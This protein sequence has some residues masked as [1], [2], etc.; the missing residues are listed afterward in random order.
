MPQKYLDDTPY[1]EQLF[2]GKLITGREGFLVGKD[3]FTLLQNMRYGP[4]GVGLESRLGMRRF[5]NTAVGSGADIDK[6]WQHLYTF[7]Q[8]RQEDVYCVTDE[9]KLY[10]ADSVPEA[11]AG[12]G[13][14]GTSLYDFTTSAGVPSFCAIDNHA[15]CSSKKDLIGYSGATPYAASVLYGTDIGTADTAAD[16][17]D[18]TF[19]I[20]TDEVTNSDT[21]RYITIT[22]DTQ[23]NNEC[24]YVGFWQPVDGIT[25]TLGTNLNA[26][27][28][29][30][31]TVE[32]WNG[33]AW[34]ALTISD[35]TEQ[36]ADTPFSQ[37]GTISWTYIAVGT[38][39]P[40]RINGLTLFWYRIQT[41]TTLDNFDLTKVTVTKDWRDIEDLTD[42]MDLIPTGFIWMDDGDDP[43]HDLLDRVLVDSKGTYASFTDD[44]A[45]EDIADADE[46]YIGFP[47]RVLGIRI[48]IVEGYNN[49]GNAATITASYWNGTSWTAYAA[50]EVDDGTLKNGKMFNQT[51]EIRL[52]DKGSSVFPCTLPNSGIKLPMYWYKIEPGAKMY[53]DTNDEMRIWKIRGIPAPLRNEE[54]ENVNWV[55]NFKDR[56]FMFGP[57]DGPNTAHFSA[58]RNPFALSGDD[59]SRTWPRIVFGDKDDIICACNFFN[60]ILVFKRREVWM[61]EG[62]SPDTFG[63]LLLDDTLGCVAPETAK[64]VRTW[65]NLPD[66]RRDFR[67]AVFFL[68]HDGLWGC[69]GVKCWKI[70]E[71]IDNYFNPK[72]TSTVIKAG[73]R[74]DSSAF[75]DPIENEYHLFIWSGSTPT[76]LEFVYNTEHQ[77]WTGPFDRLTDCVC[78]ESVI[79]GNDDRCSYG[80]GT[81]GRLYRLEIGSN[82]VYTNGTAG[83]I[84][85]VVETGDGWTGLFSKYAHRSITLFG[86]VQSAG[87]VTVQMKGD[88]ASNAVTLGTIS[89]ARSGYSTFIGKVTIGG[90]DSSGNA[91]ENK[92]H[93]VRTRFTLNSA[94][95]RM[96][97]FGWYMKKQD[98]SEAASV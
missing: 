46:F 51:G 26:T 35:G 20:C 67:H 89:M 17:D 37:S 84:D 6:I 52:E 97:L 70:S 12:A 28:S 82:D 24:L 11:S 58:Y 81:D 92:F 77:K 93:S 19:Q 95:Q 88:G 16:E 23:A 80:G 4:G 98:V 18:K 79:D 36:S 69:D 90:Q 74:D 59:T 56:L 68:S 8:T 87:S 85:Q 25:F 76:L 83:A 31:L 91:M 47:Q 42:G 61:M 86:K 22:L 32:Y 62:D 54:I 75:F 10:K 9:R 21:S 94:G 27:G 44:T 7:E 78:G 14:L 33:S 2:A 1:D 72:D 50:D 40:R 65:V 5:N 45:D 64:L 73:Y 30:E 55:S 38:E 57:Q 96:E 29:A 3:N 71:D 66:G 39:K 60:E 48:Y 43:Y 13:S 15:I 53:N 49:D 34:T 63:T 41:D